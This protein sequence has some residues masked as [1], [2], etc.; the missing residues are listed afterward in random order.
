MKPTY[1]QKQWLRDY[2]HKV[3]K[4][5]ETYEEVYDHILLAI[6]N[7]PE[8]EFFETTIANVINRDFGGTD[9]LY[10][11]EENCKLAVDT[12]AQAQFRNNFKNW[13]ISQQAIFTVALFMGLVYLQFSPLKTGT[14]LFLVFVIL[15]LLPLIICS[16]R[17]V[18]LGYKYGENKTSIKDE[19]FRKVAFTSDRIIWQVTSISIGAQ[20]ITNLLFIINDYFALAAGIF[21]IF[22]LIWANV[23]Q[24]I[25]KYK[26][27]NDREDSVS[28]KIRLIPF[29][30][31]PFYGWLSLVILAIDL[32]T[33]FVDRTGHAQP[34]KSLPLTA[35]AIIYSISS[36]VLVAMIINVFAVIK[37]YNSEFKTNMITK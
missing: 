11:L 27:K 6:A 2:L 33:K 19:V 31:K 13:F 5:R 7:E 22:L 1:E 16:V 23:K 36:A 20:L 18:R 8:H 34:V 10:Q 29:K 4:Y 24:L 35:Y 37:L 30:E 9:G 28:L 3:M 15:L 26:N 32:V 21:V 17:A 25:L 14:A 12:T